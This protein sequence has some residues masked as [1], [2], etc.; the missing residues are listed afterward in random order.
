MKAG[1]PQS[2]SPQKYFLIYKRKNGNVA[3]EKPSEQ[4][5]NQVIKLNTNNNGRDQ[6]YVP[7]DVMQKL[8]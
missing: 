7:P 5:L 2:I 8:L 6:H 3:V 1:Q 4:D